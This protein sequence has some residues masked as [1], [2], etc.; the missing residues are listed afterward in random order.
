MNVLLTNDD[1]ISSAGLK[2]LDYALKKAGHNVFVIA[3]MRQQSG[4]AHAVTVFEPLLIK[5]IDSD[6]IQGIGVFG[7]PADCVKLGLGQICP[8]RPDLVISGINQG[9]N[10]G[11]DIFYSGTVGAAAE[12]AHDKVPAM[13]ISNMG[14]DS[15]EDLRNIAEHA[16][17]L[18]ERINWNDLPSQRVINVNYPPCSLN[19]AKGERVCR[20]SGISWPNKYSERTDPRGEPYWWFS[21]RLDPDK[22][23]KDSDRH[24]LAQGYITITPL[25]FEYTDHAC[26][27]KLEMMC[28]R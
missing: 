3:P 9:P 5:K 24:L 22:F 19:K 11:P 2:A 17:A 10:A 27:D 6:E 14:P 23:E 21:A 16:I 12:A 1:G 20:Q 7:T 8:F 4:V 18:A 28:K 26:L 15:D 25:Q 13:A